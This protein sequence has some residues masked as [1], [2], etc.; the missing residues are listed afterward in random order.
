M[1]A[2]ETRELLTALGPIVLR[3]RLARCSD[4]GTVGKGRMLVEFVGEPTEAERLFDTIMAA[5]LPVRRI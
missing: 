4:I 3:D 5:H 1:T 2:T